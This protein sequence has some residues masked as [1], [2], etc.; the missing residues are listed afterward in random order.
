MQ[1][2]ATS[3]RY[4]KRRAESLQPQARLFSPQAERSE[5]TATTIT[6]SELL[7]NCIQEHEDVDSMVQR[8]TGLAMIGERIC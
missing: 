2:S 1:R 8:R 5:G 3:F 7:L 6:R 4:A